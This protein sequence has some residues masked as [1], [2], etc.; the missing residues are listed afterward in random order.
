MKSLILVILFA[1]FVISLNYTVDIYKE[2]R[3]V[4]FVQGKCIA[5]LISSGI[6]RRDIWVHNGKCGI[7]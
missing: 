7:K 6:E 1:L 5:K 4:S 3:I 2:M